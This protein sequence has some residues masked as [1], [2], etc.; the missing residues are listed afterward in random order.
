M[1]KNKPKS[2]A[3]SATNQLPNQL[4]IAHVFLLLYMM[5]CFIPLLNAMDYDAPQWLYVSL[6]NI[7]A[8]IFI[9]KNNHFFQAFQLQKTAKLYLGLLAGFFTVGCLSMITAINASESLVHLSRFVNIIVAFFCVYTF[10]RKNPKAFFVFAC[11]VSIV[12]VGFY[13]WRAVNYFY[14]NAALMR[15]L[16]FVNGLRSGFSNVNIYTAFI[17][18]QLP[19]LIYGFIHFT[20]IW[21][22]TSLLAIIL[23]MMALFLVGSRSAMVSLSF[24]FLCIL[25]FLLFGIIKKK[26]T[27]SL[28]KETIILALTPLFVIL[29]VVNVNKIEKGTMNSLDDMLN[30]KNIDFY[31]GKT[32]AENSAVKEGK[33]ANNTITIQKK[34]NLSSGRFSLWALAIRNFK[35]SPILGVG[36]GNYKAVGKREHYQNFN[37]NKGAFANPRRAHN[38]FLEKLAETGIVG[39]LLY[40]SLFVFPLLWFFKLMRTE[41]SY[42]MQWVYFA[43]FLV[44]ASYTFDALL[45][46]PLERPPIQ[47]YFIF[48]V[49]LLIAFTRSKKSDQPA[50]SNK[51]LPYALFGILFLFSVVSTAS[52]YAILSAYQLQRNLRTDL[53]G[54]TLFSDKKLKN[55]FESVKKQWT[56]YPQ[57]SY[58][59]TVNNVFL[60]NYAIKAKQYDEALKILNESKS[61]NVDALLVKS[62][63]AEIFLNVKDNLD[64]AQYYS[65]QVFDIFPAF[66]TNYYMLKKIYAKR[67]DTASLLNAMH[68]YSKYNPRDINEWE[69]KANTMYEFYKDSDLMLKVLDTGIAY[70]TYSKKLV[71]AKKEVMGKLKFKS[72]LSSKEVKEK[73]QE[74]YDLFVKQQYAQARVIFEKILET[75]PRDFL[76]VQNIGI[77][78]LINKDYEAAIKNLSRVIKARAF[79]DGKAEYSRGYCYEQLGQLEKAKEDYRA[80]RKKKYPQAMSLPPSKYEE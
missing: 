33:I 67:K 59:G 22:Y 43:I 21:K 11:K 1:P 73:H 24:M 63:K 66:K 48:T 15:S 74:A 6:L 26:N 25:G 46:F 62:F 56:N 71:D 42:E 37:N 8:L 51:K 77:I 2:N 58:V 3:A 54:K 44:A 13:G 9:V 36:Y 61:Y 28:K 20:K 78:D 45:N 17:A 40:V 39:F 57:L 76:S 38:D 14:G 12:L 64:S 68:R 5:S 69:T 47:F 75:N 7:V 55:S 53:M 32:I 30:P 18:V 19:L 34:S 4:I 10:V 27:A 50:T 16:E 60:A 80:S 23:G 35:K 49:S 70:N 41:T 65:E 52:N 31:K 72:Y 29:M 79:V